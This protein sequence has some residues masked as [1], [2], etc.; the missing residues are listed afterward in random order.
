VA[1]KVLLTYEK[2]VKTNVKK[3]QG[4]KNPSTQVKEVTS[5]L[6]KISSK[7]SPDNPATLYESLANIE[8]LVSTSQDQ[9]LSATD[10]QVKQAINK[11]GKNT[12]L[13]NANAHLLD[14][15]KAF[16]EM[17]SS[18]SLIVNLCKT[19]ND[20]FSTMGQQDELLK[21]AVPLCADLNSSV[22]SAIESLALIIEYS[23]ASIGDTIK[24]ALDEFI[25]ALKN[26]E[27]IQEI[28]AA[29]KK[30]IAL[31]EEFELWL[32][33][34]KLKFAN[35]VSE[36]AK[37]NN[38]NLKELVVQMPEFSAQSVQILTFTIPIPM[39]SVKSWVF[40]TPANGA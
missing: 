28:V 11:I 4:I 35:L 12:T 29:V 37:K 24:E 23:K 2:F 16:M 18:A 10:D 15:S 5:L 25:N 9:A 21:F 31:F 7:K 32:V 22:D 38:W 19:V 17:T 27:I 36:L 13:D 26:N 40:F 34:S 6:K 39:V 20:K 14:Y 3:L 1:K 33:E 8:E 30:I